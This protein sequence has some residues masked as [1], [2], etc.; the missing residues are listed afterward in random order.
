MT[1]GRRSGE[2]LYQVNHTYYYRVRIPKDLIGYFPSK[3][4]RRSLKTKNLKSAKKLNKLWV[5]KTEEIFTTLRSGVMTEEQNKRL[6][7]SYINRFLKIND[8]YRVEHGSQLVGCDTH[9]ETAIPYSQMIAETNEDM[10]NGTYKRIEPTAREI[11]TEEGIQVDSLDELSYK[12]FLRDISLAHIK[13]LE[14]DQRRELGDYSDSFSTNRF[15]IPE[16]QEEQG[17]DSRRKKVQTVKG[18]SF[19]ELA[20]IYI[21]E[22]TT[23]NEWK[24][25]TET[26]NIARLKLLT[27]LLGAETGVKTLSRPDL[28]KCLEQLQRVPKNKNKLVAYKTKSIKEIL[29]MDIPEDARMSATSIKHHMELLSTLFKFAVRSDYLDKNYAE[30]LAPKIK[31][32]ASEERQVYE[33]DDLQRIV[34][35]TFKREKEPSKKWIPLLAMYTGMRLEEC[36]QLYKRDIQKI[37]GIW[38]VQVYD[39]DEQSIKTKAGFRRVPIHS[40]LIKLGFLKYVQSVK[41]ERLWSELKRGRDG[42]SDAFGKWYQRLNRGYI[43]DNKKKVFHSFRHTVVTTLVNNEVQD[44][45]IKEIIGHSIE[46]VTRNRYAKALPPSITKKA[47]ETLDYGLGF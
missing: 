43:T 12:R 22:K 6:V 40:Q 38:C 17:G 34:D 16:Q 20:A 1:S 44:S 15:Y 27:E 5:A 36:C 24:G 9:L 46:G 10:L 18:I 4:L 41:S 2:Y 23:K 45:T 37:D 30:G 21:K 14:I 8:E 33:R 32:K 3:D 11:L 7:H 39:A 31:T 19:S 42:Y 29:A 25:K 35:F 47:I 28:I 26:Q 13:A